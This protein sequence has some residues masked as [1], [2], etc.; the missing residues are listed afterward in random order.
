MKVLIIEN[1]YNKL[2]NAIRV[3][4]RHFKSAK[5][6]HV[7]NYNDAIKKCS[8]K[9][10]IDKF[11]LIILDM[12]FCRARP[13]KNS[14]PVLH[15]QTGSMFLAHLAHREA[16]TPVIIYS[17]A[18]DYLK[19]YKSFLFP[20]F[21]SICYNHDSFPIF[22]EGSEVQKLYD[23]ATAIGEKLLAASNFVI[24]HAHDVTEFETTLLRHWNI[25]KKAG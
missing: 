12:T 22:V 5:I 3:L 24:G 17:K 14:D 20:S 16:N 15:P 19:I 21:I 11:D 18:K 8:T 10:D 9:N 7:N 25:M 2:D 1:D 13:Y 6:V 4:R 23:E